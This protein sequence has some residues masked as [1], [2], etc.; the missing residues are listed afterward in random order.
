VL[1]RLVRDRD[2]RAGGPQS[3]C[4]SPRKRS[5]R[6]RRGRNS[7]SAGCACSR[8]RCS[9]SRLSRFL[10]SSVGRRCRRDR[11][12]RGSWGSLEAVDA[13]CAARSMALLSEPPATRRPD[14]R[15][16]V[17]SAVWSGS[18]SRSLASWAWAG[19][20][21]RPLRPRRG[22]TRLAWRSSQPLVA[23]S[24]CTTPLIE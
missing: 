5:C 13:G 3:S 7:P 18:V 23:P 10:P 6:A 8:V 21:R 17:D 14:T 9:G 19:A 22:S 24:S 16:P 20:S 2:A 4:S 15:C 1:V 12:G 11:S